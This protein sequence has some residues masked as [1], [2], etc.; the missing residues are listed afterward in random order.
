MHMFHE[1]VNE[2]SLV[3]IWY[4][5]CM[6]KCRL[7]VCLKGKTH[8]ETIF[9]FK[10]AV[11]SLKQTVC[12]RCCLNWAQFNI[13]S[14]SHGV[15][16][17]HFFL[18]TTIL[19][20]RFLSSLKIH[21]AQKIGVIQASCF[22]QEQSWVFRWSFQHEQLHY[23]SQWVPS[24][25]SM[26]SDLKALQSSSGPPSWRKLRGLQHLLPILPLQ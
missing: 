17:K 7:T 6:E 18:L 9:E 8:R 16:N 23:E 22:D 24:L 11:F 14:F 13:N 2:D 5:C 15:S 20:F 25:V 1:K 3:I 12:W 4:F 10:M 19:H 21:L 26:Y